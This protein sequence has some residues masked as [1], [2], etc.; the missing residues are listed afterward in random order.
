MKGRCGPTAFTR[1]NSASL[2]PVG[3]SLFDAL[4]LRLELPF[5]DLNDSVEEDPTP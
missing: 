1:M 3:Q 5:S 4:S 2:A